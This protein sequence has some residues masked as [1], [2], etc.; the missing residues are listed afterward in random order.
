[1]WS[2]RRK[3]RPDG[4]LLKYKC[5]ICADGSQR[6]QAIDYWETYSPVVQWSTVRLIMVLAATLDLKSCQVDYQQ[7]FPKA[8]IDEDVY[9]QIP[10]GWAYDCSTKQLVQVSN[11][12]A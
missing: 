3:G 1:M 6:R 10:K 4:T 8:P 9:M 5:R 7:A 2:Y 11:V 12:P